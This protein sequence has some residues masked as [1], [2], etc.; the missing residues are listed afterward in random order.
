MDS[1]NILS[2]MAALGI[3]D[4]AE[5]ANVLQTVA[6]PQPVQ[7]PVAVQVAAPPPAPAAAPTPKRRRSLVDII[8][9]IADGVAQA[10]GA[11]PMYQRTLDAIQ[12]RELAQQNAARDVEMDGIKL[13]TDKFALGDAQIAR[14]G[15]T[16]RGVKAIMAANPDATAAQ[17]WPM[18]AK[19][20]QIP[21]DQIEAIGQKIA[22]NPLVLDG[23]ISGATDPKL[24]QSKYGGSVVYATGPDGK[25]AAFQPGLGD[26]GGRQVLPEGFTP[27]DP[28]KF[29][30]TGGAQVGVGTR[31]G[32]PTRI[33][34]K[35]AK[36]DTLINAQ[37]S[38]D[39]NIRSNQTAITIAGMPARGKPGE[40]GDNAPMVET[41]RGS[42]NELR[43]IYRDLNKMGAMVSPKQAAN[44][45][46]VARI[47]ASGIGQTLEGA[48]GTEAQTKRDRVASIRPQ[49]MQSLAKAT[50]M[51]GK[52]LDSNADVKL[53]MQTVTNPAASYEANI[54]AIDGL[55]RF[56][57]ANVKKPS[58]AAPKKPAGPVRP[59]AKAASGWKIVGV[60]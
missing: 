50:G 28:L 7:T 51:T 42:L 54:A 46:V 12:A 29:V 52:Q 57:Q 24:Q 21:D 17:I 1:P 60:K 11:T 9:N 55:E 25:L 45:N 30:D 37:T 4:P 53:F 16:A 41:A 49:L 31:S 56:L 13:A 33:L 38:R 26:E 23:M 22:E 40:G 59:K 35:S 10:G 8:G 15:Q 34:P 32:K 58:A 48:V 14:L 27:I 47:R 18:L 6:A 39:N 3:T 2:I 36:P 44:K 19:Q 20:M 5:P 43:T